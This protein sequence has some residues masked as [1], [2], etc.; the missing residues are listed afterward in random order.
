[1]RHYEWIFK[2]QKVEWNVE[3][4]DKSTFSFQPER[5]MCV[6]TT[7]SLEPLSL[8]AQF[9]GFW[10]CTWY[11]F[12]FILDI[13]T[14]KNITRL[15]VLHLWCPQKA[16]ILWPSRPLHPQKSTIDLLLK[17][18]KIYKHI[19]TF[20]RLPTYIPRGRHKCKVT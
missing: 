20:L 19:T 15:E 9:I 14:S 3:L 18:N 8:Y 11:I 12:F 7:I 10:P 1:M 16:S 2:T 5:D 4:W 6:R 17:N 13:W